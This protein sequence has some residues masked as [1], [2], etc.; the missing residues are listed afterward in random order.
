MTAARKLRF[1]AFFSVPGCHPTGWR[2]PDAICETDISFKLLADMARMAERG[3]LD[4]M[5]FQDSVA[6]PGSTAV[7]GG[8]AFR[9]R[10]GR[11]AHIEPVS[12]IAA[13]SA[14]TSRIGLIST[15]TTS[16]N[17]PYNVARRFLTIDHISGGRAGWNLVTSQAE[18]EA[19]NFGRDQHFEHG[20]RYDRASEFH[21]VV[22]GLWDSWEDDAFL[23]DKESGVWFDFDKMHILRHKG[24]H[25]TVRGPLNVARSPQGRPVVAQAG[26]SDVGMELA[27][28]TADMVFTAQ[29]TIPEGRAFRDDMHQR[30]A[31]YGRGPDEIRIFPGI[32]PIV[33]RS[34]SEAQEK[35]AELRA[36]VDDGVGIAAVARLAGGVDIH[37]LDPDGPLP[38]LKPSNAA[39]ARQDRIVA[40]GKRGMTIREIGRVLAMSQTHRVVWGTPQS[41]A[42]DL[43]EWLEAGACD[44]FN[45]LFAHY[46]KPLEEWV[47]LV[48]PELQRRGLFRTEY[49]GKT[50]RENL[51]VPIP[52]NIHTGS[53]SSVQV[54]S[55]AA[56]D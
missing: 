7:Y 4:C 43:H 25:F 23:R 40:M 24:Q 52:R 42:D 49:E 44:G 8:K 48:I 16:Y 5:F 29:D 36:L 46:P 22:V 6:I 45:L 32:M 2:H 10:N 27:A 11:Q 12:A 20:I 28:R 41:I 18:D 1:G 19:V 54:R 31:K 38:P 55:A 56:N 14:L 34:A 37:S 17:E 47:T 21:D 26:S 33:G 30:M 50:F 15:C 3:K 35:Y 9:E 39:R 53:R 51:G 13:I